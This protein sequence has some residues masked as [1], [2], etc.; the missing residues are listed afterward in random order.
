VTTQAALYVASADDVHGAR[1]RVAGR[2]VAFRTLLAAVRA[3][4]QRVGVPTALRSTDFEAALATSPRARAALVWLDA[5]DALPSAPTLLLPAAALVPAGAL[6]RL[7]AAAPGAVLAESLT[8][9]APVVVADVEILEHVR[10]PL[11]TGALL[12]DSLVHI[13]KERE[14]EPVTAGESWY[15]RVRGP[16]TAAEAERR[17]YGDLGSPIDTRLDVMLHRRLSRPVSRT[18]V[19]LGIGPNL[20]T[21]ASGL[22][23]LAAAATFALSTPIT[24]ILGLLVYVVA[25]VLD[26]ADGEVARLTLTESAFGEWLDA[27]ID[28]VVHTTLALAL[29]YAASHL[30]GSGLAAG[31]VAA[32]GILVGGIIGKIW[33]PA[34]ATASRN[35][36]DR[37]TSRDGFYAMLTLFVLLGVFRPAL[38]PSLMLIVAAGTH[39]YWISRT[40][41]LVARRP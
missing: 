38:L 29:G 11:V 32:V 16:R 30:A 7:L 20:I 12:G 26:H 4:A 23:G 8:T 9:D 37:L 33:P 22:V 15:V 25:V 3:G 35:L 36:L 6:A 18:A 39:I 14:V 40:L 28:T 19:A 2:P 17:L 41:V 21:I 34:P 1:L 10:G 24:L 31:V 13:L 5:P 27:V